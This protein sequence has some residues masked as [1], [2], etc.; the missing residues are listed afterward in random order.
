MEIITYREQGLFPKPSEI[1][2][3]CSCP[4]WADMCKHVAAA[5][6]GVGARLDEKPE[7]LFVLRQVDHMELIEQA[8]AGQALGPAA[9]SD[10]KTIAEGDLAEVFGIEMDTAAASAA[11]AQSPAQDAAKAPTDKIAKTQ[12]RRKTVVRRAKTMARAP[13]HR[14]SVSG[15]SRRQR[16]RPRSPGLDTR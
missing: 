2:L 6:Y 5:L 1:S 16:R 9:D 11:T 14:P 12:T 4:D 13:Q 3:D 7:L 15:E 8:A 10:K